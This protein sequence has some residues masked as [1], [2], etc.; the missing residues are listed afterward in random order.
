MDW[1][2]GPR[3]QARPRTTLEAGK[4]QWTRREMAALLGIKPIFVPPLVRRHRLRATGNGKAR[5]YPRATV[6][7]LQD[8]LCQGASVETTNQYLTHLKSYCNWLLADNR[9]AGTPV[10][11]LEPGKVGVDRRHDRRELD[12]EE[13]RRLLAAARDSTRRF[14]GL[15]GP[16][17]YHLY[18]VAC[19]T[20]F[21]ASTLAAARRRTAAELSARQAGR[22]TGLG[23][24]VGQ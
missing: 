13:L 9:M 16:D 18:A 15:T 24:D 8:R 21:R 3:R 19:G 10:A 23:R 22:E 11:H 14:R 4:D 17:R 12:A 20:G 5:R 1:L 7:A 6:E 2:A